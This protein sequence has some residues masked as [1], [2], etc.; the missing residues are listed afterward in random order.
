MKINYAPESINDLYRLR[1][2]I[3]VKNPTA[4]EHIA[5]ELLAGINKL[6]IFPKMSLPV[7][8]APD[9]EIVR[10]LYIGHY[11]VRY[12]VSNKNILVLRVWHGKEI[13]KDP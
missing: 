12:L 6:K 3:E 7:R 5:R 9:P 1:K 4:T 10:D 11:V 2:F 8:R 13:E